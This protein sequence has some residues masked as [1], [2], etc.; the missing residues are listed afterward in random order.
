MR[1]SEGVPKGQFVELYNPEMFQD[2]EEVIVFT[3]EEFKRYYKSMQEQIDFINEIDL[4]LKMSEEWKL[5]GYW[6]KLIER[7]YILD[8]NMDS[9]LKKEPL[10]CYLDASLYETTQNPY[11][12]FAETKKKIPL[13]LKLPI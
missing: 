3:R 9:L 4:Y 10:Q 1:I 12:N 8:I 6:P 5:M 7:I 13:Q 11:N 2:H